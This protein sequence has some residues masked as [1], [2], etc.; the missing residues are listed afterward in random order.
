MGVVRTCVP[1]FDQVTARACLN[2]RRLWLILALQ[3]FPPEM[4]VAKR[5]N[6][7]TLAHVDNMDDSPCYKSNGLGLRLIRIDPIKWMDMTKTFRLK[8]KV[9]PTHTVYSKHTSSP[10][11]SWEW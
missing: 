1:I 5:G 3:P 4:D 9:G 8:L 2:I 7:R 6:S 11:E 10:I